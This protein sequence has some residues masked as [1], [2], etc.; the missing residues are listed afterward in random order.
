MD[1]V[2]KI[3]KMVAVVTSAVIYC[4]PVCFHNITSADDDVRSVKLEPARFNKAD[5]SENE[6][7]S[8]KP[9][10]SDEA[11]TSVLINSSSGLSDS[12]IRWSYELGPEEGVEFKVKPGRLDEGCVHGTFKNP[13]KKSVIKVELVEVE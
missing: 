12:S 9:Q 8:S 6:P 11:I 2:C 1:F 13:F 10:T 7:N 5:S 4:T 3:R